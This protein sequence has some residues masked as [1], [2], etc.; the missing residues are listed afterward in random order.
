[1][2]IDLMMGLP[3]EEVVDPQ[4]TEEYVINLQ[5]QS[6]RASEL[7]RN[8]LR[9]NA[10]RRKAE[11]DIRV[12]EEK[13]KVGDWVWYWYPRRYQS[14]SPKWQ[15]SY[16]GPFLVVRLIEPVNCVLQRT[17]KSKPFVVHL[18]K[19]KKCFSPTP[20]SWMLTDDLDDRQNVEERCA[21]DSQ[22]R[23]DAK[24]RTKAAAKQYRTCN[25]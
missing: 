2:P 21:R 16:I 15:K 13:F 25:A 8:H 17:I 18:D 10:E 14:K 1:M 22:H 7:A 6:A 23:V 20:A 11:Y 5:L 3:P 12:K 19:L 4:T 24:G 9:A